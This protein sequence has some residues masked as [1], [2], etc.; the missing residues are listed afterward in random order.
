MPGQQAFLFDL[1]K[2]DKKRP[3]VIAAASRQYEEKITER[4]YSFVSKSPLNTTNIICIYLPK[5][6]Q[7]ATF[8]VTEASGKQVEHQL[9][10][11]QAPSGSLASRLF[12]LTFENSPDGVHVAISH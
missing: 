12:W 4:G 8:R 5:E 1:K 7:S 3:Q 11:Y 9:R 10:V 2:I 6:F